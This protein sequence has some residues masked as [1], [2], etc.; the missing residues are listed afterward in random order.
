MSLLV[1][2]DPSN[3][4]SRLGYYGEM[5]LKL[6]GRREEHIGFMSAWRVFRQDLPNRPSKPLWAEEFVSSPL[7]KNK[8]DD[9]KGALRFVFDQHGLPREALDSIKKSDLWRN[10]ADENNDLLY[11]SMIWI[12]PRVRIFL[13]TALEYLQY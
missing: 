9:I 4:L 10:L 8:D 11:F 5:Y 1:H 2:T 13:A 7:E 6:P 12:S 3:Y